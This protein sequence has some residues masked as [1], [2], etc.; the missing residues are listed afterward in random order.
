MLYNGH[1]GAVSV[2]MLAARFSEQ[3]ELGVGP[4]VF[5]RSFASF[6]L[7]TS[8]EILDPFFS[9]GFQ[10]GCPD[11]SVLLGTAVVV[12]P[13]RQAEDGEKKTD[14]AEKSKKRTDEKEKKGRRKNQMRTGVENGQDGI[15]L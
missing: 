15:R 14:I 5:C 3:F 1:N 9:T 11:K 13:L 4:F 7:L 6:L 10:K 12:E 8:L 2:S